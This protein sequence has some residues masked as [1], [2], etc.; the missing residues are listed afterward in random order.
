MNLKKNLRWLIYHKSWKNPL[1]MSAQGNCVSQWQAEQLQPGWG[2]HKIY[3]PCVLGWRSQRSVREKSFSQGIKQREMY[4]H[5]WRGC[6][7][8]KAH[9][10]MICGLFVNKMKRLV[11]DHVTPVPPV[12]C[13][14][15]LHHFSLMHFP[16]PPQPPC[17]A[18]VMFLRP[19]AAVRWFTVSVSLSLCLCMCVV[20][21][22]VLL[23]DSF[24]GLALGPNANSGIQI[25][26]VFSR[27]C[28]ALWDMAKE[29]SAGE[30]CESRGVS[31]HSCMCV[32]ERICSLSF[33]PA[34]KHLQVVR[35]L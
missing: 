10:F 31:I 2:G 18:T 25:S 7:W 3:G 20:C 11:E 26:A 6:R 13:R 1:L 8:K 27:C 17:P 16:L 33:S 9:K 21:V 32:W 24:M 28:P 34:Q 19:P 23:T 22:C 14:F 35:Q 4:P 30:I 15:T 12:L 29:A 5:P